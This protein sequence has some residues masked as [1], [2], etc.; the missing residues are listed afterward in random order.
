MERLTKAMDKY[1]S[2]AIAEWDK[3]QPSSPPFPAIP[4]LVKKVAYEER[5]T[6][7]C[8]QNV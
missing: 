7:S 3:K 5:R 6:T 1:L 2:K 4:S 8:L